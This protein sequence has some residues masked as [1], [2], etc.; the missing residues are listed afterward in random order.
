MYPESLT[1]STHICNAKCENKAVIGFLSNDPFVK[2]NILFY[3]ESC[4]LFGRHN[5]WYFTAGLLHLKT[6]SGLNCLTHVPSFS[7]EGINGPLLASPTHIMFLFQFQ[8]MK[9]NRGLS[10]GHRPTFPSPPPNTKYSADTI[11]CT[12]THIMR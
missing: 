12:H 6:F 3:Q 8:A 7:L 5:F 9:C 10:V 11:P 2:T 1:D 4:A